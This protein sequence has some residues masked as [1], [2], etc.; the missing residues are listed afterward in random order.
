MDDNA[1]ND[2]I[3]RLKDTEF[4]VWVFRD[5]PIQKHFAMTE[6]QVN[7]SPFKKIGFLFMALLMFGSAFLVTWTSRTWRLNA[8]VA[9]TVPSGNDTVIFVQETFDIS[10]L[11][12]F[13]D[14]LGFEYKKKELLW[15][16]SI[17]G[18]RSVRAGRYLIPA[19]SGY[20]GFLSKLARGQQDAG[21]VTIIPGHFKEELVD[22][23]P[24]NFKFTKGELLE[25]LGDRVFLDSIGIKPADVVAYLHPDTYSMY[26]TTSPRGLIIR[27]KSELEKKLTDEL[28]T[29]IEARKMTM[30]QVLT[31]ASII[32]GEA[33]FSDE[34][35]RIS[36]LYWNRIRIGMPLQADPT[37]SYALGAK[38]R[39]F[40]A[41]YAVDH[42]Y[43]TYKIQGL[44]PGPINNPSYK[45]IEA[46]VF[47]ERHDYLYMVATPQGRHLFS[48]TYEEHQRAAREWRRY[49]NSQR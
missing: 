31:M 43:N 23:I 42:P 7:S 16:S 24:E 47:P 34:M 49:L 3:F 36:G 44:P 11:G 38:R 37:V 41:D 20:R 14:S 12:G 39:L 2:L 26:W 27:L 15:A 29:E 45:A 46:A 4:Q 35:P 28:L 30:S 25:A 32:Q 1:I 9:I 40:F 19:Q 21:Q 13:L 10:D 18:Y 22:E 17:F 8:P 48:K 5:T 6:G 33:I